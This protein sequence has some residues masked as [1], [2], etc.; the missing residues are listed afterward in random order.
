MSLSVPYVLRA[1][2][3]SAP[4]MQILDSNLLA[5]TTVSHQVAER[6]WWNGYRPGDLIG[7]TTQ[8]ANSRLARLD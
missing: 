1:A 3:E 2:V 4:N 7:L 8:L 6:H 5:L